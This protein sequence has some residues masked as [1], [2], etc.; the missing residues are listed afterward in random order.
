MRKTDDPSTPS[1]DDAEAFS[2]YFIEKVDG[3][4]QGIHGAP[5]PDYVPS[6]GGIFNSF[7][8]TTVEETERLIAAAANERCLLDPGQRC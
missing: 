5:D 4:R 3:M 6:D 8:P 1:P 2:K 7:T